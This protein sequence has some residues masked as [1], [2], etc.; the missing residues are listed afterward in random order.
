MSDQ[1]R[2]LPEPPSIDAI[3]QNELRLFLCGDVMTG[4]GLD[5]VLP[6]PSKPRLYESYVKDARDYVALAEQ[7]YGA[8][9]RPV[10]FDYIWGD[11]LNVLEQF[12]PHLRIINL[13][14]SITSSERYWPDKG[15]NYRMHPG[16][17]PCLQALKTDGCALANNHLLDW[18]YEGLRET[19]AS[20]DKAGIGYCGAGQNQ[21]QAA[22][23]LILPLNGGR[24]LILFSMG[25]SSSGIP[26]EWAASS[27]RAGV[28]LVSEYQTDWIEALAAQVKS[29]RQPGDLL[30]CSVHWGGNWG[31]RVPRYRRE[32]AHRLINQ[33]GVDLIHGHS[34]HHAIGIECY[35]GRPILY[36]CGDFINDYEGIRGMEHYRGDLSLLYLLRFDL[37]QHRLLQLS[38]CP[39]QIRQM[40]LQAASAAD[41]RWLRQTL[42]R[43]SARLGTGI[44][45]PAARWLQLRC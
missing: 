5:Q 42:H 18:G 30:V 37:Q 15:I 32:M 22:Q 40:R 17:T 44:E 21:Q 2:P 7:R 29:L 24:R 4:R 38:L 13:E 45:Q 8:I 12:A 28:N 20:L 31:Y 41:V 1:P 23:P 39:M 3:P 16:N 11:A 43:E 9:A 14:T 33:A 36:G 19:L 26:P 10:S 25:T 35:R 34:S 6:Y 27:E